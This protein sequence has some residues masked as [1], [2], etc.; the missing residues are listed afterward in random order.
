MIGIDIVHL[1]RIASTMNR[2]PQFV[3]KFLSSW[4]M[5]RYNSI[6][7]KAP[8]VGGRWAAK[9]SIF[10]TLSTSEK[11]GLL[12]WMRRCDVRLIDGKLHCFVDDELRTDVHLSISHDGEYAIATSCLLPKGDLKKIYGQSGR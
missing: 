12:E 2:Y 10:K 4:E 8:F 5:K 6:S 7:N 9:E 1:P 11:C 3:D